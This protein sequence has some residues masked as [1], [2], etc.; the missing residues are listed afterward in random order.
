[1]LK[2][3]LAIL[4]CSSQA[5][6]IG[7]V[8]GGVF[9][10]QKGSSVY[11]SKDTGTPIY[12][13]RNDNGSTLATPNLTYGPV[14]IDSTGRLQTSGIA[15]LATAA[16]PSTINS[17]T[18]FKLVAGID[19][20]SAVHALTMTPGG[21][22]IVYGADYTQ[23]I[24]AVALPLPN[25]AATSNNQS[26]MITSL[27]SIDSKLT[28]L[29]SKTIVDKV[30]WNYATTSVTTLTLTT[31]LNSLSGAVTECDI[32]DSSGQTLYFAPSTGGSVIV[33]PGGNGKV[34]IVLPAT[35][36]IALQAISANATAGEF[37][38]N[39]YK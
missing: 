22:V 35:T 33:V 4:F 24:S 9:S 37:D 2:I 27:A 14:S 36:G 19:S 1:M 13:V 28:P 21:S 25:G 20:N 7:T 38:L 23:P 12:G 11:N 10:S 8:T 32:F 15:E 30:R 18:V 31:V 34:P 6:A 26:T 29:S 17:S 39:C 3:F 16:I 5:L